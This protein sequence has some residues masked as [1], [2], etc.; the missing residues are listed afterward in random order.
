MAFNIN[1]IRAGLRLGGARP[2]LF[3]VQITNPINGASDRIAPFLIR[4]TSLP[5]STINS[6][7]I[8]YFGRKIKVAGDR[9]FDTWSVTVMNDEDFAIRQ[10][11]EEWHNSINALQTNLNLSPDNSPSNY[12]ST[13]IVT[14]FSK[15]GEALRVYKFNGIFPVEIAPI[16]LD[17]ETT[18]AIETFGVTFAYDWHEVEGGVTGTV[19]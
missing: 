4:S 12:K 10:T 17:W 1:D 7:E 8:P 11:M 6:I 9:T 14:Q 16:E 5:A 19:Q 15:T 2:T 18:D 3:Q 13:A